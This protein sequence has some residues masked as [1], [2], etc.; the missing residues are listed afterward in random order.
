MIWLCQQGGQHGV[1][2]FAL[3]CVRVVSVAGPLFGM[4]E[5]GALTGWESQPLRREPVVVL[6]LD[7]VEVS[8]V[9]RVSA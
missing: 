1:S 2:V 4:S 8:I 7:A 6:V 9:L 5:Q 3:L